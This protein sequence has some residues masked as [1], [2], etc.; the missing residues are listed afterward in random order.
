MELKNLPVVVGTKKIYSQLSETCINYLMNFNLQKR[1]YK[2]TP[3]IRDNI[4][5][6]GLKVT[7]FINVEKLQ[8]TLHN[9]LDNFYKIKNDSKAIKFFKHRKS[10]AQP[11]VEQ[12]VT[13]IEKVLEDTSSDEE[14]DAQLEEE[15]IL[16]EDEQPR[17]THFSPEKFLP[18]KTNTLEFNNSTAGDL[19]DNA[20]TKLRRE[21]VNGKYNSFILPKTELVPSASVD[22]YKRQQV[23]FLTL[24]ILL[25][26]L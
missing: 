19:Q 13:T 10:N 6:T 18:A 2:I 16:F 9:N 3:A 5:N 1:I 22:I 24:C 23:L 11:N 26:Q 15:N 4:T 14:D 25:I 20:E 21:T 8:K 7:S 17:E 12:T